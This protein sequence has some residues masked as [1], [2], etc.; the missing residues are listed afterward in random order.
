MGDMFQ[1]VGMTCGLISLFCFGFVVYKIWTEGESVVALV[2]GLGL[3][4]CGLG[5][6]GAYIYGWMKSGEWEMKPV[7][8]VWTAFWGISILLNILAAVLGVEPVS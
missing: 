2:C 7:M 3:F 5:Y 1:M 8:F 4:V 6:I